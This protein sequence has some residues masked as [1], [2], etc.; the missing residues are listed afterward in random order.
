MAKA[1]VEAEF[2]QRK[3]ITF[4]A[5][6]RASIN[7]RVESADGGPLG[8]T[9]YELLLIALAN[10]TMGV[11]MGHDSLKDLRVRG[12]TAT[13]DAETATAPARIEEITVR[14]ELDV[15]GATDRLQQTLQRVAEACPI[16]NT[17]RSTPNV[18]VQLTVR[19]SA[20]ANAAAD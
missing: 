18:A 9:S 4:T 6:E 3:R 10:C 16:G 8:Y 17:L 7:V 14:L 20:T 13:L 12:F 15:E 1:R 2:E 5:R 11:V 19:D